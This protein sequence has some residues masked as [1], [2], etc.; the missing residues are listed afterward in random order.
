M[1]QNS[2]KPQDL[3]IIQWNTLFQASLA[4]AAENGSMRD[5]FSLLSNIFTCDRIY[6]FQ[7]NQYGN[8]DCSEEWCAP[9]VPRK[10][11]FMQNLSRELCKLYYRY[12][13]DDSFLKFGDIEDLKESDPDLYTVLKPQG[14]RSIVSGQLTFAGE[15]LG[16]FGIDNPNPSEI[17][18]IIS[19]LSI[20][21]FFISGILYSRLGSIQKTLMQAKDPL[22]RAGSWHGLYSSME[23]MDQS[24]SIGIIFCNLIG[25]ENINLHRGRQIGDSL[26]T[27]TARMIKSVF[28]SENAYRID[29][30][31]FVVVLSDISST[32]FEQMSD[33]LKQLLLD[34]GIAVQYAEIWDPAWIGNADA[35]LSRAKS[36]LHPLTRYEDVLPAVPDFAP[37]NISL[38]KAEAFRHRADVWLRMLS[39]SD[40]RIAVIAIDFNHFTLFNHFAGRE[41]ANK[42]LEGISQRLSEYA[43]SFHGTAG[44]MGG[45]NFALILPVGDLT[46]NELKEELRLIAGRTEKPTGFAPAFGVFV[47]GYT[48]ESFS[49]LYDHALEALALVRG[50]YDDTV[51]FFNPEAY[52]YSRKVKHLL[53]DIAGAIKKGEFIFYV[54]PRVRISTGKITSAEALVR[55]QKDGQI[56]PPSVFLKSLEENGYI[57]ALDYYIWE[58]VF[59]WQHSLI[60]KGLTPCPVSVNV[61][62]V[63]FYFM[64]VAAKFEDLMEDYEVDPSLIEI[65]ITESACIEER[66]LIS[67]F[68]SKARKN[69]FR[70]LMDDFGSAASSPDALRSV[71]ADTLII[72][73]KY[74]SHLDDKDTQSVV[75]SIIN[76]AHMLHKHVIAEGVETKEQED[77][78]KQMNCTHAQG[79]LYY[80]PMKPE[81]YEK[82]L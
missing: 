32:Y 12:Y 64:D 44:Y 66:D 69:G 71:H 17:P 49:Q 72:D 61:S 16:F 8:Y 33:Q 10:R 46:H 51:A 26:L 45:D 30:D 63:D 15:D 25:L 74:I 52:E 20:L 58:Q 75:S 9:G 68:I 21:R 77:T 3:T 55:W 6:I 48:T 36:N 29:G 7:K 5:L 59:A 18:E 79:Y 37:A 23:R 50:R 67:G 11:N 22:T 38:P 76:I 31:D 82:L 81:A 70:V 19:C 42:R 65:E 47:T 41:A 53:S 28:G 14:V 4:Q 1:I 27:E 57:A 73:R 34:S 54:Q 62:Q 78:L 24:T 80:R 35:M 43:S 40:S 39:P 2:L 60:Q 56:L 13:Q